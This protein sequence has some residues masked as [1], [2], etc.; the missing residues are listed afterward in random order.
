VAGTGR[1]CCGSGQHLAPAPT[2][3]GRRSRRH[4]RKRA[5]TG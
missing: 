1:N 5:S 4:R 3:T 2:R